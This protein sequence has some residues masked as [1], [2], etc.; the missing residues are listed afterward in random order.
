VEWTLHLLL[1]LVLSLSAVEALSLQCC[2]L[3]ALLLLL[4]L[5]SLLAVF[6]WARK[7]FHLCFTALSPDHQQYMSLTKHL[8][9]TPASYCRC[10]CS[11]SSSSLLFA[12]E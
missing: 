10:S 2:L 3:Q 6:T 8:H 5:L 9:P 7:R 1:T 12:V 11:S 4:L